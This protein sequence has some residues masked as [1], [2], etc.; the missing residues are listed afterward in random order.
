M[1]QFM[2][3][4]R[5]RHDSVTELNI[6]LTQLLFEFDSSPIMFWLPMRIKG[7]E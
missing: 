1:L 7:Y 3:S 6:K 5:V 4:Q 2:G